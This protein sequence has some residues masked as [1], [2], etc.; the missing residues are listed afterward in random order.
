MKTTFTIIFFF[1]GI[2]SAMATPPN[3]SIE[4]LFDG[5]YNDNTKVETTIIINN[6]MHYRGITIK[7]DPRV[8]SEIQNAMNE[9][10]VRSSNYTFHQDKDASYTSMQFQNNGEKIFSGLQIDSPGNGFFY[11]QAKEKAFK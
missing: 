1:I 4:K 6:G 5:R 9:D 2:L 3:L 8:L 10:K 7:G 11:I